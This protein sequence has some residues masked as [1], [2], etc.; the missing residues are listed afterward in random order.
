MAVDE[1]ED[2][3]GVDEEPIVVVVEPGGCPRGGKPGV[4]RWGGRGKGRGGALVRGETRGRG[5]KGGWGGRGK[6][7]ESARA[8]S[9]Q[10]LRMRGAAPGV[11]SSLSGAALLQTRKP[12]SAE[13]S[14]NR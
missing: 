2:P 8:D 12:S 3:L 1:A 14:S 10:T 11:K 6:G 13:W 4:N 5:S 7:D 9:I